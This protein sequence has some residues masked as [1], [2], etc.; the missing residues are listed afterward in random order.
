MVAEIAHQWVVEQLVPTSLGDSPRPSRNGCRTFVGTITA[1]LHNVAAQERALDFLQRPYEAVKSVFIRQ[2]VQTLIERVGR[3]GSDLRR[4]QPQHL[5]SLAVF[6]CSHR[7]GFILRWNILWAK[8]FNRMNI[9]VH[10]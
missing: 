9:H 6:P 2:F 10:G 5:L 8:C 3:S 7:H 1:K 4:R